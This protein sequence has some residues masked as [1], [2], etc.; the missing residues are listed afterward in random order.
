MLSGD[1]GSTGSPGPP[2]PPSIALTPDTMMKL[3]T[4]TVEMRASFHGPYHPSFSRTEVTSPIETATKFLNDLKR[5]ANDIALQSKP[6]GSRGYPARSCRDIADYYP[7]KANGFHVFL[8]LVDLTE[9]SSLLFFF[10]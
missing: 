4:T 10:F 3:F 1:M 5:V 8:A 6:D 2:G 7:E 9:R